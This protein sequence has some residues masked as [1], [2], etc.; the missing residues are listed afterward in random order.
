MRFSSLFLISLCAALLAGCLPRTASRVSP[1]VYDITTMA[2]I[3]PRQVTPIQLR[4]IEVGAPSWL[5]GAAMQYR[6]AY[7]SAHERAAYRLGRWAASPPELLEQVLQRHLE[8][9]A[10][11]DAGCRLQVSVDEFI[12][13]FDTPDTSRALLEVRA[14]LRSPRGD[15][16][17]ASHAFT[18]SPPAGSDA[19][20]GAAAFGVAARALAGELADWLRHTA[21]ATPAMVS[22][23][24]A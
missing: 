10:G 20:S 5:S 22:S 1:V 19:R 15:M 6:L 2:P 17:L 9:A 12:Q 18:L 16:S 3:I 7:A 23:C 21:T 24:R 11:H 4:S 14:T 13:V 8:A